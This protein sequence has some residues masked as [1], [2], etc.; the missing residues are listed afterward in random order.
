MASV[1][2]VQCLFFADGGLLALG[3]NI[4]N[5]GFVSSYIVYPARLSADQRRRLESGAAALRRVVRPP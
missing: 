4:F 3:A 5:L 1:L 2:T